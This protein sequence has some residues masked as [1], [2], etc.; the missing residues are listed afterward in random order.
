MRFLTFGVMKLETGPE[1][2]AVHVGLLFKD[3][4]KVTSWLTE[5][6]PQTP[7]ETQTVKQDMRSQHDI[8]HHAN[9]Q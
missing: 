9:P 8:Y 7:A 4:V 2:G 5:R 1:P 3:F 6:P